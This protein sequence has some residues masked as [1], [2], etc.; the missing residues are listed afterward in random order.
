V[1]EGAYLVITSL[2][3]RELHRRS[4]VEEVFEDLAVLVVENSANDIFG[5]QRLEMP[6]V[7]GPKSKLRNMQPKRLN[8]VDKPDEAGLVVR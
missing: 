4:V 2:A 6:F 3:A 5:L 7:L 1:E 8:E